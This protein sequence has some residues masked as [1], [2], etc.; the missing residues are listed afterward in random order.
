MIRRPPRSTLF[1]YTTLFR[2]GRAVLAE[3]PRALAGEVQRRVAPV[4]RVARGLGDRVGQD[5]HDEGLAVPEGVAVVAG[6]RQ[7]LGRDGPLL[8]ASARLQRVEQREPQG[9]LDL[10][11]AVDL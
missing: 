11:V 4:Q 10:G 6:T 5:G 2:S 8:A 9:L 3:L 7:A 1:P